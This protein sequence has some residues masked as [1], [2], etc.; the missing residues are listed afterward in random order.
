MGAWGL[1]FDGARSRS[2]FRPKAASI[3]SARVQP[4]KTRGET[5]RG[6]SHLSQAP[7]RPFSQYDFPTNLEEAMSC[8]V[9]RTAICWTVGHKVHAAPVPKFV[10]PCVDNLQQT[11]LSKAA[12]PR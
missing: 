5:V 6:L 4:T 7:P 10:A 12:F 3:L 8:I 1:V 9:S 2:N 11:Y